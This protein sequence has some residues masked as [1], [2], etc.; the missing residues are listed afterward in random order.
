MI[1]EIKERE[2]LD[3]I[4]KGE[5]KKQIAKSVGTT[6]WQIRKIVSRLFGKRDLAPKEV[7]SIDEISVCSNHLINIPANGEFSVVVGGDAHFPF[8]DKRTVDIFLKVIQDLQPKIVILLGD[9]PD[10]YEISSYSKNP[11]RLTNLQM[12]IDSAARFLDDVRSACGKADIH[13]T[14]GNH[15]SRLQRYIANRSP[16]LASLRS[17]RIEQLLNIEKNN[18][19]Y[20]EANFKIGNLHYIHGRRV[21][22]HSAY[23]AKANMDDMGVSLISGHVHRMGIHYRTTWAGQFMAIENGTLAASGQEYMGATVPNWQQGFSVINYFNSDFWPELVNIAN[24][25]A[26]FRGNLYR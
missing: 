11:L 19:K 22:K 3:R 8:E 12:E 21:S 9:I 20:T 5:A 24:G 4:N 2:I 7:L 16:E 1:D 23:S 17:L 6:E 25:K 10:F 18:I 14:A 26:V 15:E 13:Y